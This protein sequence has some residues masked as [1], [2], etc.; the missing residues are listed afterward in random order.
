MCGNSA[1]GSLVPEMFQV[2]IRTVS[3]ELKDED[4][5]ALVEVTVTELGKHSGRP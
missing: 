1:G 4:A 5:K 2:A 3:P